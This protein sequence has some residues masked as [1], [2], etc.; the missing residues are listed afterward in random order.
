MV[1]NTGIRRTDPAYYAFLVMQNALGGKFQSRINLNLRE[2]KGYTYGARTF[3]RTPLGVGPFAVVAA[4]QRQST[5]AA[6]G[7]ILHEL[8]DITGP[9]P[10]SEAELSQSKGY[11]IKGFPR[12]FQ[13]LRGVADQLAQHVI[14]DLPDGEWTRYVS[15]IQAITPE[16]ATRAAID[17]VHPDAALIV[18][19]GDRA[20]IEADIRGLGLGEVHIISDAIIQ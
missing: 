6:L 5:A 2:D 18:V 13:R 10:L 8:R 14:Y 3:F 7:E 4:V 20:K 19:V 17:L 11:L 15:N 16:Q 1:G 9:R 12:Q